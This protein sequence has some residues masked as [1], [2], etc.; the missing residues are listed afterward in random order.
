MSQISVILTV[1][2]NSTRVIPTL[3]S[4]AWADEIIV[5]DMF[6][7][8]DTEAVCRNF[9]NVRFFQRL[10]YVHGNLNFGMDQTNFDWV[11][12]LDSDEVL[13][14][15]LQT[16]IQQ[17]VKNPAED[18]VGCWFLSIQYMFGKPMRYGPGFGGA[19]RRCM[20]RRGSVR[21]NV[22]SE[23]EDFEV[24][25][26]GRWV[27]LNGYYEHFTNATVREAITKYVYYAEEDVRRMHQEDLRPEHPALAIWR[28]MRLFWMFYWKQ[29]GYKDGRFGF[30][31][32]IFRG[33]I[34]HWV[35]QAVIWQA[36]MKLATPGGK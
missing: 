8:D 6:S 30:Y 32:A 31:A 12:K 16:S 35:T 17:F 20:F 10:D 9:S 23:H 15:E 13:N 1:F 19:P 18:I 3:E 21:Y 7:K 26:P 4:I 33:A 14:S 11:I 24:Q 34:Q 28:G 22:Q 5:V 25:R 27:T 2:N 36:A 29:K